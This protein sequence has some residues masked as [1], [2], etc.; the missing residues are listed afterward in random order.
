MY[1]WGSRREIEFKMD[2]E[3]GLSFEHVQVSR[4]LSGGGEHY[5]NYAVQLGENHI[6]TQI[7]N[8]K[9]K[10]VVWKKICVKV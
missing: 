9:I 1:S 4:G 8:C 10:L 7:H 6:I 5:E 2:F 3:G